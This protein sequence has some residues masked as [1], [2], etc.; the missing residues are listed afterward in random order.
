[1]KKSI[2]KQLAFSLKNKKMNIFSILRK[3]FTALF[4]ASV[5]LFSSCSGLIEQ[6]PEESLSLSKVS[7]KE[8]KEA[9]KG[10]KTELDKNPKLIKRIRDGYNNKSATNNNQFIDQVT[11]DQL[12]YSSGLQNVQISLSQVN[13]LIGENI[14]A[15]NIGAD[16]YINEHL[17]LNDTTINYL[18]QLV[19][20]DEFISDL[21]TQ[22]EFLSLSS[23]DQD[24][25][26]TI[27][28][29]SEERHLLSKYSS[30]TSADDFFND[31]FYVGS[32]VGTAIGLVACGGVC[33]LI[34]WLVGGIIGSQ[35]K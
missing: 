15:Q 34:G 17:D 12:I 5:I 4:L 11:L 16:D 30:K 6:T 2:N 18:D 26:V 20:D 27:N 25:L 3:P 32:S 24:L 9:Y 35:T 21:E 19:V 23:N 22:Q 8:L 31:G 28:E 33:G 1:M 10:M 13:T 29:V 14:N 7:I